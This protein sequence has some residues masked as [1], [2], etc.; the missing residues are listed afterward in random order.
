MPEIHLRQPRFTY[1]TCG[2]FTKSKDQIKKFKETGDLWRIYQNELDKACFQH[3][4]AYKD[5]K[6]LPRR[7]AS[8]KILCHKAFSI[9]KKS[10]IWW[11]TKRSCFNGL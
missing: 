4:M 10:N 6:Y 3:G 5:F 11:I 8:D 2:P 7:I 1:S 9:T